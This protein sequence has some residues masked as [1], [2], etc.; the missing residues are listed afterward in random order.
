MKACGSHLGHFGV[1]F[2]VGLDQFQDILRYNAQF[3]H[4]WDAAAVDVTDI[5]TEVSTVATDPHHLLRHVLMTENE[6]LQYINFGCYMTPNSTAELTDDLVKEL[7]QMT[8]AD[9]IFGLSPG[10]V[11]YQDAQLQDSVKSN[12]ESS[13]VP[14]VDNTIFI[15]GCVSTFVLLLIVFIFTKKMVFIHRE[16]ANTE[17]SYVA[18]ISKEEDDEEHHADDKDL[19]AKE[20]I[21]VVMSDS[22]VVYDVILG[23]GD[24]AANNNVY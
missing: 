19:L 4:G 1:K 8:L 3:K 17:M 5:M 2:P 10:D 12:E 15:I 20:G 21:V 24:E 11:V 9:P 14:N 22:P 7:L 23:D 18:T 16:S 6:E 13:V